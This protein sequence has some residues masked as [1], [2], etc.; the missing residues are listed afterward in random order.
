MNGSIY[1]GYT[2]APGDDPAH[3]NAVL[4]HEVQAGDV[5]KLRNASVTSVDLD[6]NVLGSVFPIT[7]ATLDVVMLRALP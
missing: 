2:Q 3:C 4:Q 6:P 7:I 1:S 5:L